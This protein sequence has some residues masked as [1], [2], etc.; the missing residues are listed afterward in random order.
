MTQHTPSS[1]ESTCG[2]LPFSLTA[3]VEN[4]SL[5]LRC[6]LTGAIHVEIRTNFPRTRVESAEP[7]IRFDSAFAIGFTAE[8][9]N[10]WTAGY[11][12]RDVGVAVGWYFRQQPP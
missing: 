1:V 5:Q 9:R 8:F 11:V 3:N 2:E 7:A 6:R 10:C 12:I 4:N